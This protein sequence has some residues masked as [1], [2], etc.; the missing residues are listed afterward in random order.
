MLCYIILH[1]LC[2]P[3]FSFSALALCQGHP[4]TDPSSGL[5]VAPPLPYCVL[6]YDGRWTLQ[7][8]V[9]MGQI[10]SQFAQVLPAHV[11]L[12]TICL[13]LEFSAHPLLDS[14]LNFKFHVGAITRK[15]LAVS[16]SCLN[17]L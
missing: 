13:L 5:R 14:S 15:V 2:F 10:L 12:E 9:N 1:I 11:S 3:A 6:T 16:V 17:V 7:G 4:L 8:D